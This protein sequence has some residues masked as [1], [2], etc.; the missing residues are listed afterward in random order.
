[1][2][3]KGRLQR[4]RLPAARELQPR[5]EHRAL[6][7]VRTRANRR[8]LQVE[9]SQLEDVVGAH[10]LATAVGRPRRLAQPGDWGQPAAHDG[11]L[12]GR[13]ALATTRHI[14][15]ALHCEECTRTHTAVPR[16]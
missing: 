3:L 2:T 10:N 6:E 14:A 12:G 1:M 4:D 16:T 7:D 11:R 5:R 8:L 15:A 13:D 9:P